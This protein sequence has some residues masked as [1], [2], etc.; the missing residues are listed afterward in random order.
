MFF[1]ELIFLLICFNVRITVISVKTYKFSSNYSNL[2][3]DRL[4][5]GTQ[6]RVWMIERTDGWNA[7]NG[8]SNCGYRSRRLR[9]PLQIQTDVY[10]I[11]AG[12]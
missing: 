9:R 12:G 6:C 11:H 5:I 2:F 10:M 8:I 3:W 1:F 7:I 4:F